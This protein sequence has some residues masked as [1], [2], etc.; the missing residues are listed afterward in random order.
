MNKLWSWKWKL[1]W[2][3]KPTWSESSD[4]DGH[5]DGGPGDGGDGDNEVQCDDQEQDSE[6]K[7][8]SQ[9]GW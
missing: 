7:N 9:A 4:D 1:N 8:G 5:D 6:V 2:K 3:W